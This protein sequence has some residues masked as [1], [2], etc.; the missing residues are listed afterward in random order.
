MLYK[1]LHIT[2]LVLLFA[3][4]TF[5]LNG[6]RHYSNPTTFKIKVT[7]EIGRYL[8]KVP[9]SALSKM[10][11]P[12]TIKTGI[13]VIDILSQLYEVKEIKSLYPNIQGFS[14][15]HKEFGL[16]LWYTV[17]LDA[18]KTNLL[19]QCISHFKLKNIVTVSE[20]IYEKRIYGSN[21]VLEN[22]SVLAD[23]QY[24]LQWNLNNTGQTGG[25]FGADIKLKEALDIETGNPEV[26]IAVIDGGIDIN[27]EDLQNSLW[28]NAI[29][30]NGIPGVDDD[31]NGYIDDINGYNF[32][33]NTAALQAHRHGTHVAGVVAGKNNNQIG[34]A[35][36]AGGSGKDGV[37]LMSCAVFDTSRTGG[38]E[39]ALVYAADN[40]AVVAQNSW[41]YDIPGYY[42]QSILDAIDYFI[43]KAGK[44]ASGK[45][46]GPMAGGLV[47]FAAGNESDSSKYFP[48]SYPSVLSVAA[49]NH[50][51][52][53]AYYTNYGT[54]VD[55]AA[56]GG[57]MKNHKEEGIY[58]TM[59]GNTYGYLQGSSMACPQVAGV[60]G[61]IISKYMG[62]GLT[63]DF[64][65]DKLISGAD[66]L[67]AYGMG[68]GRLNAYQSL[69]RIDTLPPPA[70]SDLSIDS[71]S[72]LSVKIKWTEVSD[73]LG[74]GTISGFDIRYA[75]SVITEN[76]FRFCT[77]LETK[78]LPNSAGELNHVFIEGLEP[79]SK[80]YVAMKAIDG[81][82]NYSKISNSIGFTTTKAASIVLSNYSVTIS[83]DTGTLYQQPHYII[84]TGSDTLHFNVPYEGLNLEMFTVFS[85]SSEPGYVFG[86]KAFSGKVAPKDSL[87]VMIGTNTKNIKPGDFYDSIII[88]SNDPRQEILILPVHL[89]VNGT[90]ALF[91][92]IQSIDFNIVQLGYPETQ[93][94]QL[95][96]IGD[97][98][99]RINDFYLYSDA[100]KIVS[101]QTK[102]QAG[103]SVDFE[104][105]ANTLDTGIFIDT[106]VIESNT[107]HKF[108]TILIRA[109]VVLS[110]SIMVENKD[111]DFDLTRMEKDSVTIGI[112]NHSEG[113]LEYTITI[114]NFSLWENEN[115]L[116]VE[117]IDK[118]LL[119]DETTELS[120][121]VDAS[122]VSCGVYFAI[123][124]IESNDPE[125][126]HIEIPVE[127]N[128]RSSAVI[129][130]QFNVCPSVGTVLNIEN[131]SSC[132][133]ENGDTTHMLQIMPTNDTVLW[134]EYIDD[135]G[136][137]DYDVI[138]VEVNES[139]HIVNAI[140][141]EQGDSVLIAE[142][143]QSK[144]GSYISYYNTILGCDSIV[145]NKLTVKSSFSQ[146]VNLDIKDALEIKMYPNPTSGNL[147][148]IELSGCDVSSVNVEIF[149]LSGMLVGNN[150]I[151]SNTGNALQLDVS[152][153]NKGIYIVCVSVGNNKNIQKL[154]IL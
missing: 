138:E 117:S 29:E 9:Q 7:P 80:Y 37:R 51:D 97:D 52:Q 77:K 147:V 65:W 114:E 108:D 59:P 74:E 60:A 139:Y 120:V 47:L 8:N 28:V 143:Y 40:G 113:K 104:V 82:R 58:S 41:G 61:L 78:V 128:V 90:P 63:P 121:K 130:G 69:K 2:S 16:D 72:S 93:G 64:V 36:I 30:L 126:K 66:K 62:D 92:N 133:W 38:F 34:G 109:K 135:Y 106:L 67:S 122:G 13:N 137:W 99:L 57:E 19:E 112:S 79:N 84:N 118:P 148:N 116:Q 55:I 110:P 119:F 18:R 56:P 96:N 115:W 17:T 14:S 71:V 149:S 134:V 22:E 45:Q 32:A 12:G 89:H 46:I 152:G 39:E 21:T 76:N 127:L 140:S 101:K 102:V 153:F 53:K 123:I 48:A 73:E 111:F 88:Y 35:G 131:V 154:S 42:E 141:I 81:E 50:N 105:L 129:T 3:L 33:S 98:T 27:H 43:A 4:L 132:E 95:K 5:E 86:K 124:H 103:G 25:L 24:S 1:K 49:T 68:A 150:N 6:Q 31:N 145:E 85:F 100:F 70:I 20:P 125:N 15:D 11:R 44:N 54:W 107:L 146:T 142:T 136:C 91:C 83:Q 94:Y 10:G 87:Q 23:P 144:T 151:V 75:E 26:I